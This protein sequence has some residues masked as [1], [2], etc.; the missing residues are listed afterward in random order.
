MVNEFE[1]KVRYLRRERE[2]NA[3]GSAES[4]L[5]TSA[6]LRR[7]GVGVEREHWKA[8]RAPQDARLLFFILARPNES[9]L[10][11]LVMQHLRELPV[12]EVQGAA[13]VL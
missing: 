5:P 3:L 8:F 13:I 1:R 2:E 6:I 9:Q 4:R 12:A 10:L 11:C 7:R